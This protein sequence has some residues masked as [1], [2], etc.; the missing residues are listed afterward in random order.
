MQVQ[1]VSK[2]ITLESDTAVEAAKGVI[3]NIQKPFACGKGDR[4]S[5]MQ[6]AELHGDDTVIALVFYGRDEV[7]ASASGKTIYITDNGKN[8]IK[9]LNYDLPGKNGGPKEIEPQ[10]WVY[11]RA[12]IAFE[13][14]G[15]GEAA[16]APEKLR[17]QAQTSAPASTA[18]APATPPAQNGAPA[19]AKGELTAEQLKNIVK[20][21][22]HAM[23]LANLYSISA[24]AAKRAQAATFDEQAFPTSQIP[25]VAT[26]IYIQLTRGNHDTQLPAMPLN[27]SK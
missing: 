5:T 24:L 13:G 19:P 3:K 14:A 7:P 15:G 23:Q 20:V 12:E 10:L 25:N 8:A 22:G 27:L 11:G 17:Q 9:R 1:P 2:L 26:A 21:K 6:R 16:P 18:T 4:Q